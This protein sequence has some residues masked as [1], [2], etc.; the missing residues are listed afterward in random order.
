MAEKK[1]EKKAYGVFQDALFD[2][3]DK[4]A[5][6]VIDM[7]KEGMT[8]LKKHAEQLTVICT[9]S[10]TEDMESL[11]KKNE[12]P[13][14]KVI[15]LDEK[16]NF[17]VTGKDSSV[18]AYSW[19]DALDNI[20]YKLSQEKRIEKK[21]DQQKADASFDRWLKKQVGCVVCDG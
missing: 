20:G 7:A 14:D 1:I 3:D 17:L 18:E 15:K 19:L 2:K 16:V 9:E 8:T 21:N 6:K 4:G 11:L 13:F 5:Y 10:S 12:I